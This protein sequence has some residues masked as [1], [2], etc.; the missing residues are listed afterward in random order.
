M[1]FRSLVAG[2]FAVMSV[3]LVSGQSAKS[4]E[5]AV[6]A[7]PA[8][9]APQPAPSLPQLVTSASD[10]R[11][12]INR[13]C[14]GCHNQRAKGGSGPAAE[15]SRKL[16][17]DQLDT[18]RVQDDAEAWERVVRKLRAGMM[19]PVNSRRPEPA[20]YKS[21]IAWLENE[22]DRGAVPHMPPPGLHR[23]NRTEYA[24]VVRDLLDL[25]IDPAKY[26]PSDDSTHGFDNMAGALGISSTLVEAYV[27]AAG[28]ISRL[29]IGEATPPTLVVYRTPEDTSQDY[30]IEGLPFGTRGGMLIDH[31]FPSDGEYTVTV[32][33]IFGDNMSPTGFGSV[34]CEKLEVLLDGE[35]LQLLDWQGGGRFGVPQPNCGGGRGATGSSSASGVGAAANAGQT[36]AAA[37]PRGQAPAAQ[38]G[39]GG[40]FFR[41]SIPK[42]TV[43]FKTTAGSHAVGVTFPQTNLA[44]TLDLDRHFTRD[45]I[46]TGPT[47]GFTFFP[48]VG[49]VRIEGPFN[50]TDATNSASRRKIFICQPSGQAGESACARKIVRNLVTRA[51]RRPA[52][53]ADVNLMMAFYESGRKEQD[54]EQGIEMA[55]ARILASPKFIY[56][57]EGEPAN[58]K[59]GQPYRIA[60]LDLASRLSFFLWSTIPDDELI[61]TAAQGRLRNPA[62]LE[63]Q[64]R[65]MLKDPRSEALAIN[66][67]GQ[68][69]NLRGLDSVG[70]LPMLFPDFDDPL[71][72]AMRRELELVFDSVIRED[73]NV[74]DLLSADYTFV[75]ERLAKH[76]GIPNTYGSQF[77]RVTLGPDMD[78]RRGLTGKGALLAT[79][80][81]PERTSPVTRGKW[82]MTNILGMSPPDPPPDVPPLPA[83][84]ADATG[85]AKEP[86]MRQKMMDH[87]VRTDC[88]TCHSMMDPIGFSL[89][90]FDGIALW[91]TEDE[92]HPIDSSVQVFDGTK[93]SGPAGLREWLLGYSDQFVQV[94]A[95]KLLTYGL[96]RGVEYRDMPLV[97]T[98]ARDASR[99]DN[100]FSALI[101]GV[102]KSQVFQMNVKGQGPATVGKVQEPVELTAKEGKKGS[103]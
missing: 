81:K 14:V 46:Q 103:N 19:P 69:L 101:L 57:I 68:W 87:R 53:L 94:V 43:R 93:F 86:S 65:R 66:F 26:L 44:P 96:G 82:V 54:F 48:H 27:S 32:T 52:S 47:P 21:M 77:R 8:T 18:A 56:R 95:E 23:L 33:P 40:G 49:T 5:P 98:I 22:L 38:G 78:S 84:A 10:E 75:N 90:N 29:A 102:V 37:T 9:P 4:Q 67:A 73:R 60:D 70:P 25:E 62:V 97:R 6:P 45:T 91:R 35:R 51:Y 20:T 30:H 39:Q 11:A 83:R 79:T 61:A 13:Y 16:A 7:T 63:Q 85:N 31:V 17:L 100:R 41:N 92:G 71:R 12:L 24:N 76:Y 3:V 64:V 99:N 72:Q 28:K 80:S 50:A 74:V 58:L 88:T 1:K 89:E 36:P 42:M 15:A 59:P 55:L 34:P 2:W